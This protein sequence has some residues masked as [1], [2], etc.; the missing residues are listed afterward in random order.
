VTG[1]GPRRIV[2]ILGTRGIPARHGGFETFAEKLAIYLVERGWEVVV[3]CQVDPGGGKPRV[4]EDSWNGV[5]R[6]QLSTMFRGGM[7]T[8]EFDL[9]ATLLAAGCRGVNLVLGYNTAILNLLLRLRGRRVLMNMDG[10][11]W[12]RSKWRPAV[13]WWLRLNEAIGVRTSQ[14]LIADHPEI[15]RHLRTTSSRANIEMIPYGADQAPPGLTRPLIPELGDRRY[16]VVIARIEPENSILEIVRGFV[17]A[18]TH[19]CLVVLGRLE[20]E[21]NKYH[22]AVI[23]ASND[24]CVFPGPIYDQEVVTALRQNAIAYVH[25][26]TVGGT[27][28]SLVEAL[29]AGAAVIAHD[30]RFNRWVAGAG[31]RY[32]DDVASCSAAM[33]ELAECSGCREELRAAGRSRLLEAFTWPAVLQAYE[34]LL[35]AQVE[36]GW[37]QK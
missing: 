7:G 23:A 33:A 10:I 12:Q 25:G 8:V 18:Q 35:A 34:R 32:F 28:P 29:G 13:R 21:L 20:P 27:N 37:V 24:E 5:R 17:N 36:P 14:Q 9:R 16:F 22:A 19:A 1:A 26:H 30:N 31:A 2:S 3:Y 6:V 4:F 15:E 11:E